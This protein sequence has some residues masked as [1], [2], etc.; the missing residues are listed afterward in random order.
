MED[1]LTFKIDDDLYGIHILCIEEIITLKK[2]AKLPGLPDYVLGVINLRGMIIPVIDFRI[3][4]GIKPRPFDDHTVI[5]I[6]KFNKKLI[7][8]LVDTVC[9]IFHSTGDFSMPPEFS[10]NIKTDY[11]KGL[12]QRYEDSDEMVIIIEFEKLLDTEVLLNLNIA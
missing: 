11:I 8:V 4:T 3:L 9:D 7:G 2:I 1:Y 10:G 5:I 12:T 6:V